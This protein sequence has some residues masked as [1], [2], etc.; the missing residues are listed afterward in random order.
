MKEKEI[1]LWSCFL[2]CV[3][4]LMIYGAYSGTYFLKTMKGIE[5][6]CCLV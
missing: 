1:T 5:W 6:N 3:L 4:V 2:K